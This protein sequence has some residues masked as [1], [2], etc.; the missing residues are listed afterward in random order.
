MGPSLVH[1]GFLSTKKTLSPDRKMRASKKCHG[2]SVLFCC[3]TFCSVTPTYRHAQTPGSF[4]FPAK[5][6]VV[7]FSSPPAA[8]RRLFR[9][10]IHPDLG[11]GPF[12]R[13]Q[14]RQAPSRLRRDQNNV[15]T[16]PGSRVGPSQ[17]RDRTS[18]RTGPVEQ[19]LQLFVTPG[20]GER[21]SQESES[22]PR[23]TNG[24]GGRPII[25]QGLNHGGNQDRPPPRGIHPNTRVRSK[26]SCRF[27]M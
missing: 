16:V 15:S 27:I 9:A 10:V 19:S 8:G 20:T 12:C 24:G 23:A 14:N 2:L 13:S 18:I 1:I 5:F 7:H 11:R 26:T 17:G 25:P 3:C 6:A 22:Y 4:F 21:G